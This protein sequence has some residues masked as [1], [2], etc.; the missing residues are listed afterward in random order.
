MRDSVVYIHVFEFTQIGCVFV[1]CFVY[2]VFETTIQNT[3]V[4]I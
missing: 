4:T 1:Y 2:C 3:L